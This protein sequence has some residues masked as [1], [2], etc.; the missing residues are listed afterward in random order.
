MFQTKLKHI[1]I[2]TIL[3]GPKLPK[4]LRGHDMVSYEYSIVA[5]GG[6]ASEEGGYLN[7]LYQLECVGCSWKKL[8]QTLKTPR[9]NFVAMLIPDEM[10][11]C[12]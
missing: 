10:T 3:S 4:A 6:Y 2:H 11:D 1:Q 5:I 12:Q 9:S 8:E 7:T